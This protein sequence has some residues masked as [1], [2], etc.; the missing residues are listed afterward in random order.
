MRAS[1]PTIRTRLVWLAVGL[2]IVVGV[3]DFAV[4]SEISLLVF[5]CVPLVLAVTASGWR[6]G[7]VT[8]LVS[9]A[10]WLI[11]DRA[12]GAHYS[13]PWVL[14]W[15]GLVTVGTY[16]IMIWLF[17][18]LLRLNSEM[19]DRVAQRTAAL[20]REIAHRQR[21]EKVVLE[22]SERERRAIGHDLHDGLGQ[23][24]TGTAFA[25]EVLSEKLIEKQLPEAS[26]ARRLVELIDRGVEQTRKL[27]KGLLLAEIQR[28][29]LVGALQE[30]ANESTRQ[31]NLPCEL[32][33]SGEII[34]PESGVATHLFRIAQEA[35]RNAARHAKPTCIRIFVTRDPLGVELTVQDNG[36][37]FRPDAPKGEGLGLHIMAHRATMIGAEFSI[38]PRASG[39]TEVN[40]VLPLTSPDDDGA[41][42]NQS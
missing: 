15:N 32:V 11:G 9:V 8:A 13:H 4:G 26:D 27:G 36:I 42:E 10:V 35:V 39:G 33:V 22:I 12:A 34:L 29:G 30:M 20:T 24:L 5:Y 38:T 28:D 16:L 17:E 37:G 6:L 14:V 21:L 41:L 7:V 1:E 25:A 23:H 40:C 31:F 18:S 2:M 19:E 3:V